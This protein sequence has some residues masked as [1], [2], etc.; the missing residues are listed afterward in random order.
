[1]TLIYKVCD[2]ISLDFRTVILICK[3]IRPSLLAVHQVSGK[4]VL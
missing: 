2:V 1:M 4:E 3:K